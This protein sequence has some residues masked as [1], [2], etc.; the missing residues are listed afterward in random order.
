MIKLKWGLPGDFMGGI[1]FFGV[2]LAIAIIELYALRA[3][4][5]SVTFLQPAGININPAPGNLV[6][7]IKS[8][9][10]RCKEV[11]KTKADIQRCINNFVASKGGQGGGKLTD[12]QKRILT[13]A[14]N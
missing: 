9:E 10:K 8:T 13:Q 6:G 5:A 7:G 4:Q 3:K 11:Y 14:I 2:L 1:I 12:E